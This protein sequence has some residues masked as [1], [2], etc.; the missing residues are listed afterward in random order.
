VPARCSRR[1]EL[2][3]TGHPRLNATGRVG[4]VRYRIKDGIVYGATTL[5]ADVAAMVERQQRQG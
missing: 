3:G 1:A 2:H 5:L 4:G